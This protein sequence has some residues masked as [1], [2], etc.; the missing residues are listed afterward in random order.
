VR[1]RLPLLFFDRELPPEHADLVAGRARVCG[2]AHG[3]LAEADAVVAALRRWDDDA[4]GG[5]PNLKV[6]SRIGAGYDTVDVAAATARG[7]VVCHTPAAPTVSTAEHTIALLLAVTKRLPALMSR[8]AEGLAA[9]RAEGMELDGRLLGLLGYGRIARRVACT[10]R[11]LGMDTIA[12]DPFVSAREGDETH[13]VSADDLWPRSDV[14]TLH[15]P[16][17]SDTNHIVNDATLRKMKPAAYLVNCARG[18]LV[19]HVALLGALDEGRLA[20]AGLDVTE[21]EPLP[22]GHPLLTHPRVIVTPHMASSTVAGRRRLYAQAIDNALA[23]LSGL[24]ATVVP[25]QASRS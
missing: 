2:P 14:I 22:R 4:M 20:G 7:I 24:P 16:A 8:A 19:D 6:I 1:D 25:E 23:V 13:L 17:T 15:A 9:G 5:G 18:S 3:E 12:Y 21:P 11:A 10:A